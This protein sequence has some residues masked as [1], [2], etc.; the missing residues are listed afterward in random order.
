MGSITDVPGL[1][2]GQAQDEDAMTGVTVILTPDGAV[3]GID[4]RGAAPGTRETELLNPANLVQKV[5]A[6]TLCGGSAYG[7]AAA[8]GVVNYLSE[9]GF[10]FATPNGKVPIVPGAVIYDLGVGQH[11]RYPD[12]L[13]GYLACSVADK[14]V[15]EGN[16][17]AGAGA[18]IGKILG[19]DSAMK[20][21]VGTASNPV[22]FPQPGGRPP[23]EYTVGA[24]VV[25]NA[26]GD[27]YL[28]DQVFAGACR[29]PEGGLLN[30]MRML[31]EGALPVPAAGTNT[32]LAVIA[33]DAP[34]TKAAAQRVAIMAQDGLSRAVRPVHTMFDGDIVFALSTGGLP[35]TPEA[36]PF[37]VSL[38]GAIAAETLV[39]AILRSIT[40][41]RPAGGLPSYQRVH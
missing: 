41:A 32:T 18:S 4:V 17:G 25:T 12:P 19:R 36:D 24:L 10:G 30:T 21:G 7:L 9:R 3:C 13:M 26:F 31:Q 33:T 5:H 37:L 38:L 40:E 22:K 8:T 20:S 23:L 29:H 28:G 16:F 6:I 15:M 39:K 27:V 1:K 11:D 34:L 14:A 35:L 2:V